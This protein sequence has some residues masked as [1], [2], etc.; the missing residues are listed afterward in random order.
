M[1]RFSQHRLRVWFQ[2]L[3]IIDRQQLYVTLYTNLLSS[4]LPSL[5]TSGLAVGYSSQAGMLTFPFWVRKRNLPLSCFLLPQLISNCL[6]RFSS[7]SFRHWPHLG[8]F[9]VICSKCQS[10]PKARNS[11]RTPQHHLQYF[12][13]STFRNRNSAA[14]THP[15]SLSS[16]IIEGV[17]RSVSLSLT[18]TL[19]SSL[20]NAVTMKRFVPTM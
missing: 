5:F 9:G 8:I 20:F 6:W 17:R 1:K 3:T 11:A 13:T 12:A 16:L 7:P 2:L 19:A 10:H 4:K 18:L 14:T 15:A